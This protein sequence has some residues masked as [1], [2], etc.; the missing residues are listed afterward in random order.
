MT[1][2][3]KNK[4]RRTAEQGAAKRA[5]AKAK[6]DAAR[7]EHRQ[8]QHQARLDLGFEPDTPRCGNCVA[9]KPAGTF[10]VDSLPRPRP[11]ACGVGKFPLRDDNGCCD[12]WK[13]PTGETLA[14]ERAN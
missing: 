7:L 14:A 13:S 4:A 8:R 12:A 9:F 2:P 10:L 3:W 11:A 6:S 5:K 1:G